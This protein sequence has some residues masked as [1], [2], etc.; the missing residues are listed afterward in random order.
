M[1]NKNATKN[2]IPDDGNTLML[3]MACELASDYF[4]GQTDIDRDSFKLELSPEQAEAEAVAFEQLAAI[5]KQQP[6]A[7][8]LLKR[9]LPS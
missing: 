5:L 1:S 7:E 3:A 6:Q 2:H 4:R 8:T 9:L